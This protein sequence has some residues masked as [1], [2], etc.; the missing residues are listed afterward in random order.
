MNAAKMT[1]TSTILAVLGLALGLSAAPALA[2]P[3]NPEGCH[4]EHKDCPPGGGDETTSGGKHSALIFTLT[5]TVSLLTNTVSLMNDGDDQYVHNEGHVKAL[6]GGQVQPHKPGVQLDLRGGGSN[7]RTLKVQASCTSGSF[8]DCVLPDGFLDVQRPRVIL[9][10][11]P[12]ETAC[13][14]LLIDDCPDIFTMGTGADVSQL[15]S[16]GI[17]FHDGLLIEAASDIGGPDAPNPGRCL[18]LLDMGPRDTFVNE[19]ADETPETCNVTVT[20]S[21]AGDDAGSGAGDGENDE[22]AIVGAGVRAI[23][24]DLSTNTVI[25][26]TTIT[27]DLNAIKR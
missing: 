22:W 5:N 4:V 23:I 20:A 18:S 16:F 14:E 1:L 7:P 13:P 27:V 19:C 3:P 2:D 12:Y 9:R 17:L 10:V 26:E 24:C 8:G 11:R 6:A 25:G 21:D 15:M